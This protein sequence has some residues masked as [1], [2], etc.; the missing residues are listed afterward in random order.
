MM[1]VTWRKNPSPTTPLRREGLQA[2]HARKSASRVSISAP[3]PFLGEGVGGRGSC[4]RSGFTLLELLLAVTIAVFLLAGL[5]MAMNMTLQQT[6]VSR[7]AVE[8]EDLSRG[9]FNK[10]T[11]DLSGTLGPL[12]PKSGGNSAASGGTTAPATT[13]PSTTTPAT[14]P[15]ASS[16]PA[17]GAAPPPPATTP[18]DATT[19]ATT[20]GA[21]DNATAVAADYSFQGGVVGQ[22][23]QIVVYTGRVPE[24]FGRFAN[25]R[26]QTRSDQRQVIYWLGPG[27]GLFRQER[28]WVTAD[29]VRNSI[30]PDPDAPDAILVAEE[31][32]DLYFEYSDGSSW[33]VDWD[34]TVP[35]PDGVTPL[36]PPRAIRVT[37]VLKIPVG[38]NEFSEKRMSQVIPIRSAPGTY[39]PP[40]VEA[41]IDG[42]TETVP[43]DPA[44]GGTTTPSTGGTT[45]S[46]G[47]TT[48]STGGTTMP[49]TGGGT[50]GTS[51][52]KSGGGR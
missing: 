32:I 8:S 49:S 16:T 34:G 19:D 39:T 10:L 18:T 11:V 29:G 46:T 15:A 50:G 30:E 45:P 21:T 27:G 35:G 48:P 47:G 17:T 51:G 52:G 33:V 20:P 3:P 36:G 25:P 40:L 42:A 6:Q 28:P 38:K 9:I 44:T 24:A 13:A 14:D 22:E 26:E 7:N 23:K 4:A 5:Y 41:P 43:A 31:V 37:L 1:L 12:P 2:R